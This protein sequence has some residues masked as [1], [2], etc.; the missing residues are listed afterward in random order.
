MADQAKAFAAWAAAD[1]R[2][3]G[4]APWHWDSRTIPEVSPAQ[5]SSLMSQVLSLKS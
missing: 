4:Y 5:V 2:V 3:A 1:P